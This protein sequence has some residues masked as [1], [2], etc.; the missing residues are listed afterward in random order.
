MENAQGRNRAKA[1]ELLPVNSQYMRDTLQSLSERTREASVKLAIFAAELVLSEKTS[2]F[3]RQCVD[4]AKAWVEDS[5]EANVQAARD[6][7]A[8]YAGAHYEQGPLPGSGTFYDEKMPAPWA[9]NTAHAVFEKD[10]A[11]SAVDACI[12]VYYLD[13]S[14]QSA[15][16]RYLK[17][18]E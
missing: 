10:F 11:Q 7:A 9:R 13:K 18:M 3:L 4:A 17:E 16:N 12:G 14:V 6:A 2:D 1:V 15:I 5:S 8:S